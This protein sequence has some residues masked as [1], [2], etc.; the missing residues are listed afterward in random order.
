MIALNLDPL[1][2][3]QYVVQALTDIAEKMASGRA[4]STTHLA[5]SAYHHF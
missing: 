1:E 4:H 5:P 3:L 2:S